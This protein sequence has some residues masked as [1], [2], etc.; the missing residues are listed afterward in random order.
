M[1]FIKKFFQTFYGKVIGIT[2]FVLIALAL[3]LRFFG[4][5]PFSV[6][7]T[8]VEKVATF[9]V[10]AEGKVTA[11]PDTAEVNL[12]IQ[13]NKPTVQAAQ[14]EANEVINKITEEIKKLG[15]EEKYIKTISYSVYSNYDYRLGQKIAGYNVNITLKVKV[16]DFDKI[17]QVIDTA[18]SLG[19]NQIGQL[20]FTIDEEKFEQLKMEARKLAIEKAKK[21]AKEIARAGDLRLGRIVNISEN[22]V[23]PFPPQAYM[24]EK[25]VG[26]ETPAPSTQI[27]PGESEITVSVTLSYE[28]L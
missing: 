17:N 26:G 28:T 25:A 2:S 13:I 14:K 23:S 27:Q 18:T 12:G 1:S 15:V 7:Q 21:K 6:T 11:I 16:K 8:T 19:A 4:P 20:N 3:W 24:L 9:D 22:V 5:V 10:S